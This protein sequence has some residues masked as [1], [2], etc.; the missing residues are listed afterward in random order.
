MGEQLRDI[1]IRTFNTPSAHHYFSQVMCVRKPWRRRSVRGQVIPWFGLSPLVLSV[2]GTFA[3]VCEGDF[4]SPLLDARKEW[5][6]DRRLLR[7]L[8]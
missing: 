1:S 3:V 2:F 7:V 8:D 5:G 6:W 4:S